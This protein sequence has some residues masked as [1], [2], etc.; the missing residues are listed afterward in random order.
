MKLRNKIFLATLLPIATVVVALTWLDVSAVTSAGERRMSHTREMLL[1]EK[2]SRLE[3]YVELAVTAVG[4]EYEG[5]DGDLATRQAAA[6][7]ILRGLRFGENGY[8]FVYDYDGTNLVLP[9]KPELEGKNLLSLKD[10]DGKPLV[11]SLIDRAKAGGGTYAYKWDNPATQQIGNKLSY[12]TGLSDWRW[13]LGTGFYVDDIEAQ[14][15]AVAADVDEQIGTSIITF[16]IVGVAML[17]LAAVL[18]RLIAC[19]LAAP[20]I[21][22][23]TALDRIAQ[24]NGDL[25]CR[26]PEKKGNDEVARLSQAFNRFIGQV[27]ALVKRMADS[28]VQMSASAQGLTKAT[29]QAEASAQSQR[30]GTDR[31]AVAINQMVATVQEIARSAIE[32]E[33]STRTIEQSAKDGM[34][35]IDRA[36][37]GID[38]LVSDAESAMGI[39]QQ[40]DV[41]SNNIATVLDV[42]RGIAEQTNLL[43]LNAAIEAARAGEQGRGFA[44]VA[45]EVRT[46]AS[47]TQ[48]STVEIQ[49][50][51]ERLGRNTGTTV[52]AMEQ[53]LARTREVV[54]IARRSGESFRAV[55]DQV[56][57]LSNRNTQIASAAEEQ[58]A[59]AEEINRSVA[60]IVETATTAAATAGDSRQIGG[61]IRELGERLQATVGSFRL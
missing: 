16:A 32:A 9:P 27:H 15:A 19:R 54:A 48:Q 18:A 42:I 49:E 57:Q 34:Q 4:R 60:V 61:D 53:S 35:V 5:R 28:S 12:V 11:K 20:V 46:L 14:I 8:I 31:I 1:A 36:I 2:A 43:A 56:A 52:N 45:D 3:D 23:S 37:S 51:I 58:G 7:R 50:M 38:Q 33:S 13:M 41:E 17:V 29:A 6:K 55:A 59:A 24:G 25:T 26:L 10:P 30:E 21:E 47:R 22:V 39:A 40:L 44:V